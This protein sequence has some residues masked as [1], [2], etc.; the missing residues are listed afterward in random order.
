[1]LKENSNFLG[2]LG[3]V[4]MGL[5]GK[6][7]GSFVHWRPQGGGGGWQRGQFSR[8]WMVKFQTFISE[9]EISWAVNCDSLRADM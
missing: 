8:F 1:M 6:F 3:E 4:G 2:Y 9:I 5:L 7:N